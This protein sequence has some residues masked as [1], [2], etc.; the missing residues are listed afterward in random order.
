MRKSKIYYR[1]NDKLKLLK[2]FNFK[3][4]LYLHILH[5]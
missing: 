1:I 3:I 5:T 4:K 2:K